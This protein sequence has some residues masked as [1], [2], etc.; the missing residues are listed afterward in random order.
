V[1]KKHSDKVREVRGKGMLIGVEIDPKYDGHRVSMNM[2][3]NGVYAKETH[4]TN[5][6][7]AP[8]IVIDKDGIDKIASALDKSLAEV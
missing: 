2:L 1:A 4:E 7:I 6:R 3:K 5:L 8:P